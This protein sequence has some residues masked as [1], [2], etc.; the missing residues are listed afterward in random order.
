MNTMI[1]AACI[2][3]NLGLPPPAAVTTVQYYPVDQ[4]QV[5]C[6]QAN[7]PSWI[8]HGCHVT[9]DNQMYIYV[10]R[11]RVTYPQTT[12][13]ELAH[14]VVERAKRD[15]LKVDI[16]HKAVHNAGDAVRDYNCPGAG[17]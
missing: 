15:G 5:F 7:N 2:A 14:D 11:D 8:T 17:L 13:R 6:G 12:L 16:S 9:F 4:I 1:V 10:T 3:A